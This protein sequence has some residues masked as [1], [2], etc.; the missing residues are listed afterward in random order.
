MSARVKAYESSAGASPVALKSEPKPTGGVEVMATQAPAAPA[1]TK[2]ETVVEPKSIP[3]SE[4]LSKIQSVAADRYQTRRDIQLG[5]QGACK[6]AFDQLAEREVILKTSSAQGGWSGERIIKE[7][8]FAA[9]M[10]HPNVTRLLELGAFGK[11]QVFMTMPFIEGSSLDAVIKK[12]SDAGIPGLTG[13]SI[14]AVA[15]LFDKICAGVEH[16]HANG[17][18][19]LDL[20]PQNVVVGSRGEVV[21]VDWG[22]GQPLNAPEL[23]KRY[24][25]GEQPANPNLNTTLTGSL[26]SD[27]SIRAVG[28]PTYMSP[29]QWA[30]DPGTFTDRTDVYGLGAILFFLLTGHAPNQIQ[31]PQDL[32]PYFRH[33][34]VPSP[35]DYTRRRV[36]PELEALCV[37]CLARDPAQRFPSVFHVRHVLKSWLSRPEMWELYRTSVNY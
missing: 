18:L 4:V 32:D 37:K 16:A 23:P 2:Q 21:V 22:V 3:A 30:G 28:T 31:R 7:A 26:V 24:A 1:A 29:E 8:R 35:S 20:K 33:S 11:D 6:V 19:H 25:S 15:E 10:N 9:K 34:P 13:Y 12:I 27:A 17:I 5:G 36:P 14:T